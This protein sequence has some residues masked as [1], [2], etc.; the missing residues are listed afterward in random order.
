MLGSPDSSSR[1]IALLKN[2]FWEKTA[3]Y[4][5]EDGSTIVRKASKETEQPGPWALQTLRREIRY[6]KELPKGAKGLFPPLLR[7]WGEASED[8]PQVGYEIPFYADHQSVAQRIASNECSA[9]A[10]ETFQQTLAERLFHT[11]HQPRNSHDSL[12]THVEDTL[13]EA[14]HALSEIGPFHEIVTA[15]EIE[16]N[17]LTFPGINHL[18]KN[19]NYQGLDQ[20]PCVLLHGD[21]IVENILCPQNDDQWWEKLRFIDPVSVAGIA[22]G[23]PLFDLVKY[24]SYASGELLAIRSE[25]CIAEEASPGCY[26]FSWDHHAPSLA[27]YIGGIWHQT[28]RRAYEAH[29]GPIHWHC[30]HLLDAYFSLVMAVNTSGRQQWA[31]VLKAVLALGRIVS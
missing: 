3:V 19:Q 4:E 6:L 24:E 21:L 25:A 13:R 5:L 7:F 18:L 8:S 23:T 28:F 30:Y 27:P 11:L 26:R 2:G 31:R 10:A 16:I 17:G 12:A 20:G 22:V 14:T 15:K 9:H 1:Q 29:Y